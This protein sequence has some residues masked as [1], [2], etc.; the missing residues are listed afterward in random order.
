MFGSNILEVAIGIIFVYLLLSLICTALNEGIASL[1]D[2]R[3]KN[4]VEGIKNLLNDPKFTGLAQQVYNHGLIGGISQYASNPDK[5]T[6]LPSYMSSSNF[7][8]ALLDILAARGAIAGKY[9]ELLDNAE[10]AEDAYEEAREA[11]AGSPNDRNLADA[12]N[13]AKTARDQTRARLETL[14][15]QAKTAYDQA[16][17]ASS[18]APGDADLAR[19]TAQAR[20]SINSINA[21]VK[22]LDARRAAIASAKNPREV[23]LLLTASATLKE[24]L[25]YAREFAAQHPDP[26]GNIQEGLRKLPEGHTK[27]TLLVL[28]DKTRREV[29]AIEHQAEAFRE[30]LEGWFNNAMERVGGWYKRWTQRVLL[31][32]AAIVVVISNADTVMLIQRLSKDNALR[33]SLVAAAQDA[34]KTQPAV[35]LAE[36]TSEGMSPAPAESQPGPSTGM[37]GAPGLQ[38]VLEAAENIKLP[39]GWS[40][41]PNNR[42]DPGYFESPEL[43]W[44]FA[45]WTFYKLF[46]LLVSILAVSMG[47]PFW[48]DT[49]NKFVNLRSTG[50]RPGET[51]KGGGRSARRG[52]Q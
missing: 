40:F 20:N 14:A 13:Q 23:K 46:G 3:G 5:R 25:A 18:A 34:V 50:T 8:L 43:S 15:D 1:I 27:E 6:R 47:A 48:F 38:A 19:K 45:R 52:E 2:K 33:A 17:Q 10:S 36:P 30:N 31:C 22:M 4:L 35:K 7:S 16:L 32:L 9:G 11:A 12:A 49:L 37:S 42:E 44:K 39:V 26:L 28:V 41:D 51:S 21:A 24:A 29:T